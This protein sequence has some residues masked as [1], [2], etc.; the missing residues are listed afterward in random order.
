MDN[1][2]ST[3][4]GFPNPAGDSN[5]AG[6]DLNQLLI[7]YPSSTFLFRISGDDWEVRGIF[8]GDIAI[9]DRSAEIKKNSLLIWWDVNNDNFAIST[10]NKLPQNTSPWGVITA[11][12]HQYE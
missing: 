7:R 4:S 2:V 9:V 6:L 8:S 3:H 10:R 1:G 12:I 5:L 11:I